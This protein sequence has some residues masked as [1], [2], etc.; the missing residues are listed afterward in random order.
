LSD[1]L[2]ILRLSALGDIIHTLPAVEALR[3]AFPDRSIGWLVEAPY[4][5][6]TELAAPVDRVFTVATK[7]WRRKGNR[8]AALREV[9]DVRRSLRQFVARGASADFQGLVKSAIFGKMA[10]ARRRYGFDREA[11]KEKLAL[12]WVNHPV[13]VNPA[14][15]VVEWNMQLAVAMGADASVVPSP[16]L[17]RVFDD[18]T[19]HLGPLVDH[20]RVVINPGAG[21]PSKL[22]SVENF[23]A[24]ATRIERETA[25]RPLVVWGPGERE[26][27]DAIAAGSGAVVAPPT[28]LRELAFVLDR[29]RLVIAADTGPLHLAAACMTPVVGLFGPTDP[30]RN[31]PYGQIDR[32]VESYSSNRTM[33]QLSVDGVFERVL[34]VLGS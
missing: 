11:I 8:T 17:G 6:F 30:R 14:R 21:H 2:L 3:S 31:G 13:V 27:A 7:R 5:E 1:P 28:T 33:A 26:M 34:D 19:G 32:C 9:S 25:V 29:A 23:A 10:G 18:P 20:H 4:R 24:L 15:H 12:L 16:Q 22:W